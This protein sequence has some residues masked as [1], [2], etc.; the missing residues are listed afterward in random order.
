MGK[1]VW[2]DLFCASPGIGFEAIKIDFE[3]VQTCEEFLLRTIRALS[4]HQSLPSQALGKLRALFE[5]VEVAG[6]PI[7]IKVGVSTRAP[8]DLLSDT[9]RSVDDHLNGAVALV[10]AMDEV[11]IAISNIAQNEGANA[12]NQ[13]LQT[14]RSLR[15]GGS[16]LRWIVCG[17]I[18]FHHVLRQCDATEGVINDLVNL[19]LGPMED[20][21]AKELSQRLFIGIE[22]QAG[23]EAVDALIKASGAIPFL[24]HA[25]AHR[26]YESGSGTVSVEDVET[27]FVDFVDDRDESRAITHLVTRLDPLYGERARTAEGLLDRVAL[28]GPINELDAGCEVGILDDLCDDHYLFKRSSAVQWR[29]DVLRRIWIHR[30]RLR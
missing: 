23:T 25:L 13:L 24:I 14:L 26:L 3:G 29:Y 5:N 20:A 1:T 7:A 30:R 12:A 16:K 21:E 10:I 18:G 8:T 27:A 17:S 15:R 22:R 9:I 28:A 11:P 19:P 2:L 4:A 6:G